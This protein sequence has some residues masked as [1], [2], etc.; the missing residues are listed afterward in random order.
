MICTVTHTYWIV[1]P[2]A[3]N[4]QVLQPKPALSMRLLKPQSCALSGKNMLGYNL[5][6]TV[7]KPDS[8]PFSLMSPGLLINNTRI[9]LSACTLSLYI[10]PSE[11]SCLWCY[12][13]NNIHHLKSVFKFLPLINSPKSILTLPV[14]SWPWPWPLLLVLS[15]TPIKS[16]VSNL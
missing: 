15:L 12:I 4:H 2:G 7:W 11:L 1:S 9:Y 14:P 6:P 3:E 13:P 5:N 10:Q 8:I 16:M